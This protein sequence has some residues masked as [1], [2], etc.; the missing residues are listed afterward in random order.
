MAQRADLVFEGPI[1]LNGS[2][3]FTGDWLD[4]AGIHV[5][6][7]A[8]TQGTAGVQLEQSTN[9]STLLILD[10]WAQGAEKPI[11]ARYFRISV[12]GGTPNATVQI[13]VRTVS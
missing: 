9:A 7:A 5:V 10:S 8:Y 1:T 3:D 13:S 4:S 6:A 11:L 2:G 12:D